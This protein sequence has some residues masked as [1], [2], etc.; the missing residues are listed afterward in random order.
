MLWD[1]TYTD[2]VAVPWHKMCD[3]IVVKCSMCLFLIKVYIITINKYVEKERQIC[4][5][6]VHKYII[7]MD[8][9]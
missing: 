7:I 8:F 9:N 6:P 3:I 4:R 2:F 5:R 1:T